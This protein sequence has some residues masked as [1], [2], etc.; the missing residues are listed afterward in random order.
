MLAAYKGGVD[1]V[2][3]YGRTIIDG[4]DIKTGS[5][6][7]TQADITSFRTSIL[8][9]G[10]ITATMLSVGSLSAISANLGNITAGYMSNA[11]ATFIIDL[12]NGFWSVSVP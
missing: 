8:I 9:A 10:S 11:A 1:L 4:S 12:D 6:T 3:N 7:A 2:V 5:I